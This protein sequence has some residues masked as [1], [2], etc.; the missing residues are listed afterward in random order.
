MTKSGLEGLVRNV[1]GSALFGLM[2]GAGQ[3]TAQENP[4]QSDS[5][6]IT[7]NYVIKKDKE[8]LTTVQQAL[9]TDL[10]MSYTDLVAITTA[11]TGVSR[12]IQ[13]LA[14]VLVNRAIREG[15]A[16]NP[17]LINVGLVPQND[18]TYLVKYAVGTTYTQNLGSLSDIQNLVLNTPEASGIL[19]LAKGKVRFEPT[20]PA[21]CC[22]EGSLF[23]FKNPL[24]LLANY[25]VDPSADDLSQ[26]DSQENPQLRLGARVYPFGNLGVEG[27]V[28]LGGNDPIQNSQR[29]L[30]ESDLLQ[31]GRIAENWQTTSTYFDSDRNFSVGLVYRIPG[32][33]FPITIGGGVGF[34][35]VSAK[36]TTFDEQL[37]FFNGQPVGEGSLADP[38]QTR[39]E[40]NQN[41]ISPYFSLGA[42]IGPVHLGAGV[43]YTPGGNLEVDNNGQIDLGNQI[44]VYGTIG[45]N[46]FEEKK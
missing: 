17:E 43:E 9:G 24:T 10:V 37:F 18:G 35:T 25:Y 45:F 38:L 34:G 12:N 6:L 21:G 14:T 28:Y 39:F 42:D 15:G 23:E 31:S 40:V 41:T 4:Q 46:L 26:F 32:E 11:E 8:T 33:R 30:V 19:A 2:V 13:Q 22:T 44:Q 36:Q 3:V 20:E 29:E 5:T 16:E 7:P 1:L 27:G